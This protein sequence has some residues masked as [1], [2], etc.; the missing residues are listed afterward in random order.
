[1]RCEH[2]ENMKSVWKG[3]KI[4]S[5]LSVLMVACGGAAHTTHS[6]GGDRMN[7]RYGEQSTMGAYG[8]DGAYGANGA[9]GAHGA[10]GYT[11]GAYGESTGLYGQ[12]DDQSWDGNCRRS[13]RPRGVSKKMFVRTCEADDRS[14]SPQNQPDIATEPRQD[15]AP[16]PSEASTTND[17]AHDDATAVAQAPTVYPDPPT[18]GDYSVATKRSDRNSSGDA[19]GTRSGTRPVRPLGAVLGM[20]AFVVYAVV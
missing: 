9:Y 4:A 14:G 1:M 7:G 12:V 2:G 18:R 11:T 13:R 3:M 10:H 19:D 15:G 17:R 16:V 20:A 6:I 5:A 8:A